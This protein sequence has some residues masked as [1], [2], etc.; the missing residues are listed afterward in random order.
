MTHIKHSN[1]FTLIELMITVAIIGIIS[2]IAYPSYV[3]HIRKAKRADLVGDIL[4]C[5][6]IQE[7]RFTMRNSYSD[8]ACDSIDTANTDYDI[9]SPVEDSN[10]NDCTS[11]NGNE[12]CFTIRAVPTSGASMANDTACISFSYTHLGV[13]EAKKTGGNDNTET[14]WKTT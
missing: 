3:E 2:S 8:D 6:A 10:G 1:G 9:T 11:R 7:R 4:D 5:A 14:C 12:N 13:K